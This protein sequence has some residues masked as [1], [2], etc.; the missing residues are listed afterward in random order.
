MYLVGWL[1]LDVGDGSRGR[2]IG[3]GC[4]RAGVCEFVNFIVCMVV[5]HRVLRGG[6]G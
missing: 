2:E 1:Q 4:H 3:G 5:A 6:G